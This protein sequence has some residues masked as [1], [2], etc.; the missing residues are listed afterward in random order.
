MV[1]ALSTATLTTLRKNS[2][3]EL[4]MNDTYSLTLPQIAG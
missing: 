2:E 3:G 4:E 1:L